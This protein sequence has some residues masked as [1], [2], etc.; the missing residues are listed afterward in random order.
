M[1]AILA[2]EAFHIDY[3]HALLGTPRPD[4]T[5]FHQLSYSSIIGLLY[6]VSD[7]HIL[8]AVNPGDGSLVWRQNLSDYTTQPRP[9]ILLKAFEGDHAIV[10]AVGN[11]VYSWD[12]INGKL[13]WSSRSP[14]GPVKDIQFVEPAAKKNRVTIAQDTVVL[15][16]DKFG[17]IRRLSGDTGEINWEYKDESDNLPLQISI[18]Q[19]FVHYISLQAV[20]RKGYKIHI[21]TLDISD[22][23]K[24][25][26]H[27]INSETELTNPDSI[28]FIGGNSAVPLIAW[29]DDSRSIL[30][31]NII[32]SKSVSTIDIQEGVQSVQVHASQTSTSQPHFLIQYEAE[33]E[34]WADIYH[35]NPK[36]FALLKKYTIPRQAEKAVFSTS[37]T[38]GSLYFVRITSSEINVYSS[39]SD[40]LLGKWAIKEPLSR[41]V[42]HAAS[43]VAQGSA[44]SVRITQVEESG[45]WTLIN[46]GDLQWSRPESLVG[47][48]A[49]GWVDINGVETLAH[50][51]E[52]EGHQNIYMAYI[53][54]LTRH[55]KDLQDHLPQ[56]IMELPLRILSSFL[57]T[58][59]TDL[60]EF[61]FGKHLILATKSGRVAALD[62]GHQGKVVW[63]IK[64][65]SLDSDWKVNAIVAQ[66][67][68]ATLYLGDG[69]TL[70]LNVSTGD[71]L[72]R[73]LPTSALSSIAFVPDSS[74]TSVVGADA[75]GVP[76]SSV[77]ENTFIVTQSGDGKILGWRGGIDAPSWEFSPPAGQKIIRAIVRPAHDPV[78]SIGTVLGNRSVLY[79]YLNQNLA[80]I[81]TVG[82]ASVSFYLLDGVSGQILHTVTHSNVDITQPIPSVISQ[83]W[84]AYSFWSDVSETSQTKGYQLVVSELYESSLPNDRGILGDSRNYSSIHAATPR[85][86]VISQAYMISEAI[87]SMAVT[88]TRQGITIRQLLCAL[89]SS[90]A[91]VGIPQ[92][93]LDPRRPVGR[94]PTSQEAEEGLIRYNPVLEFDPR[95]YLTH[96][97]E[98]VGI[99][100]I[101]SSPT[102]FE[103]STLIF[104]YGFDIFGSRLAPSQPFDL[105]GKG[106]SKI[107]LL[108]TVVAL[109]AGVAALAPMARTKQVNL[110][111][112]GS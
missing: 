45:D 89:P 101:E 70:K 60:T 105:L 77:S 47:A 1:S 12:A 82:D 52:V 59:G 34:S 99:Q 111:W 64:A 32:G 55:I 94:D 39:A 80:L 62:T 25:Q 17:I 90:N 93:V 42:R 36:T 29:T 100:H 102:L 63:N 33:F 112:Q 79:K 61:G 30:K 8:G 76:T 37:S 24:T 7:E 9:N 20:S 53:H 107:Q 31:L 40:V 96:T 108:L 50:E 10:S 78:A 49:A 18:S 86:H 71:L 92:P 27:A 75:N 103:S 57:S 13:W 3:H 6:T 2:D 14:R 4:T 97:R 81:T 87:S 72:D 83:N 5:F 67:G 15:S 58:D 109:A 66:H 48:V 43:E 35:V 26:Q 51:L 85:P 19:K 46:N 44:V 106:F 11:D 69:S 38:E 98:V 74:S 16:G 41:Q 73:T 68:I 91:I 22:G 104:S 21:Q 28:I 95:W 65:A 56:W 110:K 54:R 88:Q 23:R 84:F